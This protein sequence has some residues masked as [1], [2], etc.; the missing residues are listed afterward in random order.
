MKVSKFSFVFI[1][2][3]TIKYFDAESSE[4][5]VV[6]SNDFSNL[7]VKTAIDFESKK[8]GLM[9]LKELENYNG[10]LFLYDVPKKVNIWMHRTSIPLD[11][12]F[13]GKQKTI[14]SVKE[15]VPFSKNLI[16]SDKKITAVL[17]IPLGCSKKLN[18]KEGNKLRWTLK[19]YY[20]IK[21]I[22]YFHCLY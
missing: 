20:E 10:M 12:I 21:N 19:S 5:A 9:D 13:I 14:I 2:F 11:I 22:G 3:L 16:S 8:K 17:E 7:V 1:F 6:N 15:G 18:I 4:F